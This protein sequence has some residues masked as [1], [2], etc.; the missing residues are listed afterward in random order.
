MVERNLNKARTRPNTACTECQRRKQKASQ[1]DREWPCNHCQA[2]KIAHLCKFAPKRAVRAANS[3]ACQ[4]RFA[5][6][7]QKPKEY[8][9]QEPVTRIDRGASN[10]DDFKLLGY[11]PDFQNVPDRG[12]E[13][14]GDSQGTLSSEMETALRTIPGKPYTDILIQH[15]LNNTN[16]QYYALYPPAFMHDYSSW[17]SRKTNGLPLSPGFTCLILRVCACSVPYLDEVIRQKLES[18]LGDTDSLSVLYHTTAKQLSSTIGP[19]KGGMTQIQ[20]LFLTAQ[21][22]KTEALFVESWHALGAAIHEAQEQ[23]MHRT[24]LGSKF[25][26]FD[27]EMRRRLWCILYAWDWQMSLL[28]SRPFIINSS[29]CVFEMPNLQLEAIDSEL[30]SPSPMAHMVLQCQIG[31]AISKIPGV[32]SGVLSPSQAISIQEETGKWFDSFPPAYSI[33]DPDTQWD[34]THQFVK[35]HRFQLHVIGYM[36]MLMPLKQCLTK[37]F[38]SSSSSMEKSFQITAVENALKLLAACDDL[39]RHILPLNAK[40]HFAPFL[41][42]D[43][44][45]LLCSA[46]VH[47]KDGS[48]PQRENICKAISKT[49]HELGRLSER[50]RTGMIC[51]R[52]LKK[53]VT[54]LSL[55]SPESIST[56]SKTPQSLID[57]PPTLLAGTGTA[58]PL[59]CFPTTDLPPHFSENHQVFAPTPLDSNSLD[60]FNSTTDLFD[61]DLGG[62]GHIWDWGNLEIDFLTGSFG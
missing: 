49:L 2:R 32:M 18:E 41:L 61:I 21:W 35:L 8:S 23:G 9:T 15:F 24:A 36:V 10:H 19:G 13:T 59:V 11:L 38:D 1:L 62:L 30:E 57:V 34:D 27:R 51:Y 6:G 42:F 33:S 3:T 56:E 43:T 53:L 25:S 47:D 45:S 48:L 28:L 50:A 46:I 37:H 5:E 55:G 17:W 7:L 31:L 54:C 58:D 39:L 20:Q 22:F 29:C 44:A 14:V 40:F 12:D 60:P 16:F 52:A 4:T 26:D